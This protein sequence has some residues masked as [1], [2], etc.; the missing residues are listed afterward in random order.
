MVGKKLDHEPT[1]SEK[2][3]AAFSMAI[4]SLAFSVAIMTVLVAVLPG[5]L[6]K[7]IPLWIWVAVM[8]FLHV[9]VFPISRLGLG[10]GLKQGRKLAK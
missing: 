9:I 4:I 5:D 1:G 6:L 7:S 8:V 2:W 3:K 10:M